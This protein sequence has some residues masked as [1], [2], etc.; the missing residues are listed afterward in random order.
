MASEITYAE[1]RFNGESKFSGAKSEPPAAPREK[2]SPHKS[3][4]GFPKKLLALLLIFLLLLAIS[5]F[6]AFIIF[7][8][9][10]S[11]LLK[12]KKNLK[13]LFHEKLA[14]EKTDLIV[15]GKDWGC[16]PENWVVS[17][18]SCYFISSERKTWNESENNC[19]GM[20]AHLLVINSEEEQQLI[21]QKLNRRFAYYVGLSD[22]EG[23][24]QWQWVDQ[25]P[26]NKSVTF[27]HPGEPS[28]PNERCVIINYIK[29]QFWGWNDAPCDEFQNSVCEMM[30]IYI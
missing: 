22:P 23:I 14:C 18:T 20:G 3:N 15:E 29:N 4:S 7:F 12:E 17:D 21:L 28:S 30:K 13:G 26:Y 19:S 25:S 6:I 27:W 10:Y 5:F 1:V 9:R 11:Q 8:Q 16:C 24:H 2:T